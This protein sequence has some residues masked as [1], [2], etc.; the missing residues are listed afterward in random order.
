MTQ[1]KSLKSKTEVTRAEWDKAI[2]RWG[3]SR[4]HSPWNDHNLDDRQFGLHQ[5]LEKNIKALNGLAILITR[6]EDGSY[7]NAYPYRAMVLNAKT[8]GAGYILTTL[9]YPSDNE[10]WNGE[11]IEEVY[12]YQIDPVQDTFSPK[13]ENMKDMKFLRALTLINTSRNRNIADLERKRRDYVIGVAGKEKDIEAYKKEIVRLDAHI[14]DARVT[15]LT[16]EEI[17]KFFRYFDKNKR[18]ENAYFTTAGEMIV[19]TKML[20]AMHPEKMIEDK[21]KPVGRLVFRLSPNGIENS[22]FANLD[23]CYHKSGGGCYPLPNVSGSNICYGDNGTMLNNFLKNGE[24][25][26][27]TDFLLVFFS[28]FPHDKGTPHVRHE[29]W[30]EG[31]EIE[32][33]VNPFEAPVAERLW[34]LHPDKPATKAKKKEEYEEARFELLKKFARSRRPEPDATAELV[35]NEERVRQFIEGTLRPAARE[36]AVHNRATMD[37]TGGLEIIEE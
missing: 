28:L 31:R 19:E 18:I 2:K 10:G 32:P 4:D 29:V 36:A 14:K 27:T 11:K 34:E 20:Y 26:E 37:F 7:F 12:L 35:L 30:M 6:S 13:T 5:A 25:Y 1:N 17:T 8:H 22:R 24:F 21:D 15:D 33:K 16:K 9:W 3:W 23:Y